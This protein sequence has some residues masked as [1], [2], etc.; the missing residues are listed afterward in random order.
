MEYYPRKIEEKMDKWLGRREVI[1]VNGPR[2]SGKTTL[3]LHLQ[4]RLHVCSRLANGIYKS[5][6]P[7]D[8]NCGQST[9]ERGLPNR[10]YSN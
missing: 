8:L 3:L 1:V 2:Q 6:F 7:S 10:V 5:I 4:E 9:S